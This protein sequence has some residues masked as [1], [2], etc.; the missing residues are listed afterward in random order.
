MIVTSPEI[1]TDSAHPDSTSVRLLADASDIAGYASVENVRLRH[2][3]EGAPPHFHRL[4]YELFFLIRG[5]L[6]MLENGTIHRLQAGDFAVIPPLTHHAFGAAKHQDADIMIII[7]PGV[8]R[9]E[10]FRIL[11]RIAQGELPVDALQPRQEEFDT[12]FVNSP[13]WAAHRLGTNE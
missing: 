8:E 1:L 4:S 7:T 5:E 9:F 3:G 11:A 2:G 6:D 12:Y 10:Y 13:E